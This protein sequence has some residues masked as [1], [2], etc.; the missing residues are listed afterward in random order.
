MVC[1][2]VSIRGLEDGEEMTIIEFVSA[3][4]GI[5]IMQYPEHLHLVIGISGAIL[6]ILFSTVVTLFGI[7][8]GTLAPKR[9]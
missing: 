6:I 9:Y 8:G 5:D 1:Y 4:I 3:I 2:L 7:I